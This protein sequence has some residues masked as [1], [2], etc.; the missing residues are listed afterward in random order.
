MSEADWIPSRFSSTQCDRIWIERR[1]QRDGPALWAVSNGGSCL[2]K[3]GEWEYEPLPSSRDDDFLKRCRF[4][5][6]E[7]AVERADAA[8]LIEI[9]E[10]DRFR[11]AVEKARR[12]GINL[13]GGSEKSMTIGRSS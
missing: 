6:F 12:E 7:E 10:Q 1:E 9:A 8:V 2:A 3:D 11:S 5:T 13:H 4:A